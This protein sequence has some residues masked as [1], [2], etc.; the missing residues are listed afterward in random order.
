MDESAQCPVVPACV[1]V[2]VVVV[3]VVIAVVVSTATAAV[4]TRQQ[5]NQSRN[6]YILRWLL[7][8][9][10]LLRCRIRCMFFCNLT[11]GHL[12]FPRLR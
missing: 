8:T 11:P 9:I 1:V 3:V 5:R 12:R 7:F 10:Q 2:V 4:A 6:I